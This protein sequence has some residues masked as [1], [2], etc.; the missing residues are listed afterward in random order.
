[1]PAC[2]CIYFD[3]FNSI[4]FVEVPI[5]F[6]LPRNSLSVLRK[7]EGKKSLKDLQRGSR[8]FFN[9]KTLYKNFWWVKCKQIRYTKVNFVLT[10]MNF[11][12]GEW[13]MGGKHKRWEGLGKHALSFDDDEVWYE[14]FLTHGH[15]QSWTRSALLSFLEEIWWQ[16]LAQ[17]LF[18][19][20]PKWLCY[21]T[22]SDITV[23]HS[24]W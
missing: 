9:I 4:K 8:V 3:L 23:L 16:Y 19:I 5:Y 13:G 6:D 20:F 18:S 10:N 2:S 7:K 24:N 15:N 21:K 11:I 12:T 17:L 14:D 22:L 1:M